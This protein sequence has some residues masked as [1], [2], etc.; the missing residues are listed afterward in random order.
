MYGHV[1]ILGE[2]VADL[3]TSLSGL[4]QDSSTTASKHFPDLAANQHAMRDRGRVLM[5]EFPI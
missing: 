1:N 3:I 4:S 2:I 5:D